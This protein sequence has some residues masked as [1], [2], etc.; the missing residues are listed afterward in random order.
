[1]IDQTFPNL[2]VPNELLPERQFTHTDYIQKDQEVLVHMGKRVCAILETNLSSLQ[3]GVSI[4]VNEPDGRSHRYLIPRPEDLLGTR[5]L[6]FVGFFGQKRD[7]LPSDYFSALDDKLVEQ[8]P[9]YP[10]ILSYSTMALENGDFSNLVLL[11]DEEIKLK[12]MDGEIHKHAVERSPGY[13]QSIRIN[14]GVL[15]EGFLQHDSLRINQVKYF[16]YREDPP[17]K[18][19]RKLTQ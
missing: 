16:D 15:P 18:A 7:E 5:Y 12:W 13:Y 1:M 11:S 10:E 3:E 17:W 8:I 4:D 19:L 14:N 6:Y 9:T 2:L